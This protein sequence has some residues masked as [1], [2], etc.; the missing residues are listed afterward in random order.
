MVKNIAQYNKEYYEKNRAK[1][2]AYRNHE[3]RCDDCDVTV[4]KGSMSKHIISARHLRKSG[5]YV[6]EKDQVITKLT[7][8]IEN[9]QDS[10]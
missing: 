1:W 3:L 10:L 6:S 4:K 8:L 9:L 5:Q 2:A 7:K